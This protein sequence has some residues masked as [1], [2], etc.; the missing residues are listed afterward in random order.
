MLDSLL[1]IEQLIQEQDGVLTAQYGGY[2][3][4]SIFQPIYSFAHKR[5]VGCEGL[6]RCI[7]EKG[8]VV[9]PGRLLGLTSSVDET[10]FMD[11]LM[12]ALHVGNFS[13]RKR[14]NA[15]LFLNVTPVVVTSGT[16][17]GTFFNELLRKYDFPPHRVVIEITE[18]GIPDEPALERAVSYYQDMGCMVAIDDFGAGHSNFE[19][20]WRLKP[21][22]VKLDRVMIQRASADPTIR[23]SLMLI[24]SLLHEIG[25]LVLAEG[26][27]TEEQAMIAITSDVDLVQGFLFSASFA[28]KDPTPNCTDELEKLH[29]RL[30]RH[31]IDEEL[32]FRHSIKNYIDTFNES[33]NMMTA[34]LNIYT[35]TQNMIDMGRVLRFYVLDA[36]GT[37]I[38]ENISS[39]NQVRRDPRLAPLFD[40]KG[41]SWSHRPYFR[42]A[43]ARP[44]KVH[45]T[46]P[47][48]S[49]TDAQMCLT[50]SR[51]IQLRHEKAVLCCDLDW[52]ADKSTTPNM[53]HPL[54]ESIP[55]TSGD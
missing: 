13:T 2:E 36:N 32:E 30:I 18:A 14:E 17:H 51:V 39:P 22:I 3:L 52:Q 43:M 16:R 47:Y 8:R 42:R 44:D 37:Q 12:R 10:I 50:L 19:R 20:I 45:L 28:L 54:Q 34:G 4:F 25:V 49:L 23:R 53:I 38:G 11:R 24:V 55:P 26:V 7:D 33:A 41:A 31:S 29:E 46:R 5:M 27:E 40:A 48:L 6:A 1:Q 21:D 15:W 9:H 35:A